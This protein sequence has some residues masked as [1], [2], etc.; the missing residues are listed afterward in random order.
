VALFERVCKLD[1]GR[2]REIQ[3][4]AAADGNALSTWYKIRNRN[5]S[6]M[7]GR[8]EQ[9]PRPTAIHDPSTDIFSLN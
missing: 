5:Y 2:R 9:M 1:L 3:V 7:V 4:R 6:Q 8:N